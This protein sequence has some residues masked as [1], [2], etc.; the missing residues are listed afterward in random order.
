MFGE[1]IPNRSGQFWPTVISAGQ[2]RFPVTRYWT[3]PVPVRGIDS[4]I[5][6]VDDD[7]DVRSSISFMLGTSGTRSRPFASGGDF[8]DSLD[9]LEPGCI[10][11]DVR[12]P[13]IDGIEVLGEL[14]RRDISW[15]VII[16][17]GHGEV[18]L[19]VETMKLG[20]IDFLEKPFEEDLLHASL[21]RAAALLETEAGESERRR[22]AKSRVASLTER[23]REVLRGLLAGMPN[24]LIAHRF[25]IS[26]RT[27]EMHRANMMQRLGVKSLADALRIAGDG[28]LKPLD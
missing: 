23:E 16:M 26:L 21:Q 17:T 14:A 20:A 5:Y 1:N 25:G 10:L 22:E 12:M 13:D 9:H 24:K 19:A 6:I 15:P 18:A 11:L 8:I 27:A 7:R 3:I 4:I 2:F 28:D